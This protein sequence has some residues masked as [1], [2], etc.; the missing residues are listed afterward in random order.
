[1]T[2]ATVAGLQAKS[3]SPDSKRHSSWPE[4]IEKLKVNDETAMEELYLVFSRGV[5]FFLWRHLGQQDLEDMVHDVFLVVAQAIRRGELRDPERL[6]GF[7]W[8]VV[9]RQVAA[10][11]D[12]SVSSRLQHVPVDATFPADRGRDPEWTAIVSQQQLMARRLLSEVSLRDREILVRFYLREQT[13]DEICREMN[14][15][16]TQFRLLK[17]RAKAR[18]AKVGRRRLARRKILWQAAS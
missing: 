9:R 13:Q 3:A 10:E 11:I 12:R 8:T 16:A 5:R 17:S 14:L 1:M 4:L 7:I 6:M 18:L 15:N 2:D